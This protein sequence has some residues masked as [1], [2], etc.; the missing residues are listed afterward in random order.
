[1]G[2]ARGVRPRHCSVIARRLALVVLTGATIILQCSADGKNELTS[3]AGP[4]SHIES[5]NESLDY[6]QVRFVSALETSPGTYR[7]DVTLRHHDEGWDHYADQWE[8]IDPETGH[9]YGERVLA[10]PHGDEQPF[11]RSQSNI[12]IPAELSAV[13]VRSRC[14]VHGYGGQALLVE[15]RQKTS[16]LFEVTRIK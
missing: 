8:V 13:I 5:F 12:E 11:V 7:F 2:A 16:T 1:M 15:L 3:P 10:H 14:N 6:S 9:V 4:R